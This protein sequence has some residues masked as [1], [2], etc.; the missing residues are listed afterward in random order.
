MKAMMLE[1]IKTRCE[2]LGNT[3]LLVWFGLKDRGDWGDKENIVLW[4]IKVG[5]GNSGGEIRR[6]RLRERKRVYLSFRVP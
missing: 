4:Q 1:L 3:I 5:V 6:Q 2:M